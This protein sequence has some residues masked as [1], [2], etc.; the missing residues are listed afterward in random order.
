MTAW[1]CLYF[2]FALSDFMELSGGL[3]NYQ[4]VINSL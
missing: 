1:D 2:D 3:V 4:G